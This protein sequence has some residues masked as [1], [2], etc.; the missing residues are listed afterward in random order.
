MSSQPGHDARRPPD[1]EIGGRARARSLRFEEKP[2]AK[3]DFHGDYEAETVDER[4]RL[5]EHV[6]PEVTYRDAS[7]RWHT[8]VRLDR[9]L[10]GDLSEDERPRPSRD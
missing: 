7:V 6:E 4:E 8:S 5:P 3:V 1:I 10:R 2:Q 9:R